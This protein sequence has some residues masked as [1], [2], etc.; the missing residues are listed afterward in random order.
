MCACHWGLLLLSWFLWWFSSPCLVGKQKPVAMFCGLWL[1]VLAKLFVPKLW[2]WCCDCCSS[3]A[4]KHLYFDPL[5]CTKYLEYY[6]AN[7]HPKFK[8]NPQ[9]S[10]L[11]SAPPFLSLCVYWSKGH[12]G[13]LSKLK[14]SCS[15]T[16]GGHFSKS[17]SK[18]GSGLLKFWHKVGRGARGI[19]FRTPKKIVK[20][21][22]CI[23]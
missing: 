5:Y 13:K 8:K 21:R 22:R 20:L 17:C 1:D 18:R 7:P 4:L 11:Y 6:L 12:P 2:W 15:G 10:I 23:P 9:P 19:I 3:L 16:Y 14:K